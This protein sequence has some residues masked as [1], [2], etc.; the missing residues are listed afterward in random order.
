MEIPSLIGV[1]KD[2]ISQ[3]NNGEQCN[4][5]DD[6]SEDGDGRVLRGLP[7]DEVLATEETR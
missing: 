6:N 7:Y 2:D 4:C 5:C 1:P 3:G